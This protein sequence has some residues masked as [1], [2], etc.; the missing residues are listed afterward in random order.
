MA[1]ACNQWQ[2]GNFLKS[3]SKK[4]L[5]LFQMFAANLIANPPFTMKILWIAR[6]LL[7]L[8]IFSK[9]EYHL[10]MD[11]VQIFKITKLPWKILK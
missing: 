9:E 4:P 8:L 2:T 1:E 11:S 6:E 10:I 7:H 5:Q 3:H